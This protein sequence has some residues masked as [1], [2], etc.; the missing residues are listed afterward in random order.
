MP[1][2]QNNKAHCGQKS[3]RWLDCRQAVFSGK[4]EGEIRVE[5]ECEWRVETKISY[6]TG[7]RNHRAAIW[8]DDSEGGWYCEHSSRIEWIG[9]C[10]TR[11]RRNIVMSTKISPSAEVIPSLWA[12]ASQCDLSTNAHKPVIRWR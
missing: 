11:S 4:A 10:P 9:L 6:R 8:L 5:R 3:K 7:G 1:G 12:P 2:R